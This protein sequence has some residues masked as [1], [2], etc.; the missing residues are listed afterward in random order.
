MQSVS[1]RK[2]GKWVKVDSLS[3]KKVARYKITYKVYY[4]YCRQTSRMNFYVSVKDD[5]APEINTAEGSVR[6]VICGDMNAVTGVTARQKSCDRTSAINVT[7]KKPGDATKDPVVE[8]M[9]YSEA[10]D[11]VFDEIGNYTIVYKVKN[12]YS[13][14]REASR[15]VTVTSHSGNMPDDIEP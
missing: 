14:Y 5:A 8:T 4:K 6:N 12:K 3:T 10:K 1:E 11:F 13:P 9:S 7:I 2:N 15:I